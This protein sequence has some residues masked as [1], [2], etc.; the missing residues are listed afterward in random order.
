MEK[1]PVLKVKTMFIFDD[2][3]KRHYY[4]FE[5][6]PDRLRRLP[7]LPAPEGDPLHDREVQITQLHDALNAKQNEIDGLR[8][9]LLTEQC[10]TTMLYSNV[11]RVEFVEL[12]KLITK[13]M[14]DLIQSK[15]QF[16]N[17]VKAQAEQRVGEIQADAE[18]QSRAALTDMTQARQVIELLR[19]YS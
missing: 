4:P 17:H 10:A 18:M 16:I 2:A 14:D 5:Q 7:V 1:Q 11:T 8:E 15:Q 19:K 12:G 9:E 6:L 13:H 3:E